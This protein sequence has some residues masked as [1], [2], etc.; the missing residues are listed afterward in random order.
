ML[1]MGPA[2]VGDA[3]DPELTNAGKVPVTELPG[4]SH[5]HYP[6]RF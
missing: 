6:T 2:T 3:L 4:A 1:N 5:F